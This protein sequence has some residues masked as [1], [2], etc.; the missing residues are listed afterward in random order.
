MLVG[1]DADEGLQH[2]CADLI[3]QRDRADLHETQ[4][5]FALQQRIN[6]DDQ[7]LH[8][9]VEKVREADGAQNLEARLRS[10]GDRER[11]RRAIPR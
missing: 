10:V 3:G 5:E 2:G 1:V 9:V 8:H 7:R 11:R 6:R 4:V